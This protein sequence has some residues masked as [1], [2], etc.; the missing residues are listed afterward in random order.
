MTISRTPSPSA[1]TWIEENPAKW[2]LTENPGYLRIY[3]AP[4]ADGGKNVLVLLT[5]EGDFTAVTHMYFEPTRNFQF[6]GLTLHLD[7]AN[8]VNF[9][10]AYCD[11]AGSCVGNG[12][13]FDHV[14]GGGMIGSNF[15]TPVENTNEAWL[16]LERIDV[17]LTGSYSPDGSHLDGHRHPHPL[18]AARRRPDRTLRRPG[19]GQIG[20]RHP[21]SVRLLRPDPPAVV[22]VGFPVPFP[23]LK[24]LSGCFDSLFGFSQKNIR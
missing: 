7:D 16:K 14:E 20:R 2:S 10:R 3:A 21:G 23:L 19:P 9:G 4:Y 15:A 22:F 1:W 12:M 18:A 24:L 13:Y 6:A 17:A 5:P 11:P 8:K